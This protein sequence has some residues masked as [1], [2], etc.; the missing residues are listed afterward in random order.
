MEINSHIIKFT[1]DAELSAPL[2]RYHSYKVIA[3]GVVE[4]Q[5][6]SNN[7]DGTENITYTFQP[8]TA[9]ILLD[10]GE[11]V[12]DARSKSISKKIRN[13]HHIWFEE[14]GE[15]DKEVSYKYIGG[16]I[17]KHFDEIAELIEK[18]DIQ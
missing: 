16:G 1:G 5:G 12:S 7:N 13:R 8:I 14:H 10:N 18:L 17:V 3:E 2:E 11:V 15:G 6:Y 9:E 4:K